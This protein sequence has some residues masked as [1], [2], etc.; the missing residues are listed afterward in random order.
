MAVCCGLCVGAN[1]FNQPLLHSIATELQVSDAQ[2]ASVV[3][4]A[5]VSYAVGLL[6]LVPLGDML[7]RRRLVL[8]LLLLSTLGMLASGLSGV[9]HSFAL[10]VLGTAM[11]GLFSVAAQVMVPM[12]S[13]LA[14]P[15]QGGRAVGLVMSGLLT[16]ILAARSV[17]G[18]LSGLAGWNAVYFVGAAGTLLSTALLARALPTVASTSTLSYGAVLRSLG[19]LI[20]EH[21]RLRSRSLIGALSFA[22]VSAVFATMALLL[23][24]P[25]HR[26]S[27]T[28]I[29]LIGIV[30]IAGALLATPVGR[31]ADQGKERLATVGGAILLL[32]GWAALWLGGSSIGWF[33]LGFLLVDGALQAVHISNQNVVYTLAPQAR[34]R[35]NAVYMTSYFVGA[36]SGSAMGSWAWL[37]G[38]WNGACAA[39]GVLGLLTLALVCW[40]RRM[41][42]R[43][44]SATAV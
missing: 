42:R 38:G 18:L 31:L 30:G 35:I 14:A 1:Y 23:A 36:A 21:P 40:D 5:Q 19:Q 43:A 3:T 12:A 2:A 11:A 20:V 8:T 22:S 44:A 10:L 32:L 26:L 13:A 17:A 34:S 37:H 6:L 15:G 25:A 28:Q 24:G 16:G 27:D 4:V 39:G 29:G 7:E 9:T 33:V 41:A